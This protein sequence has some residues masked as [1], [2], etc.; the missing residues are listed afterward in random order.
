MLPELLDVHMTVYLFHDEREDEQREEGGS[1]QSA[2]DDGGQGSLALAADAMAQCCRHE[3][4]G[5]HHGRHQ[6]T[7]DARVHAACHG[8]GQG[9]TVAQEV[10]DVHEHDDTVLDADA[11]ETD[12]AD[13]RR[14]GEVGVGEEQDEDAAYSREG[15][16]GEYQSGVARIT[17]KHVE[18]NEDEHHADGHH[19]RQP[20]RGTLL[21]FK[22]T[23]PRYLVAIGQFDSLGH[24]GPCLIDGRAHVTV[25]HAELHGT[26]AAV[27]LT[28]DN[29][30][31]ADGTYRG[32]FANGYHLTVIVG[33][34]DLGNG[35]GIVAVGLG[36]AHH[37]VELALVLIDLRGRL[38]AN[39][40]LDDALHVVFLHAVACQPVLVDIDLQFGLPH[41]AD[42]T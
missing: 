42:H 34:L 40:H 1:H 29:E 6:H 25:A 31:S 22:V 17:E 27:V 32:Q 18:N 33:H 38:T 36:I 24:L 5:G 20:C 30:W 26:V 39:G 15:H 2:D 35:L 14:N 7:A 28:V 4:E 37:K 10:L 19:L 8:L 21:V 16:I 11:E 12:E 23:V 13:A 9:V 3:T 41:V